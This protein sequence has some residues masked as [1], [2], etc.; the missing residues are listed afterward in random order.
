MSKI[1]SPSILKSAFSSQ[2]TKDRIYNVLLF[3]DGGWLVDAVEVSACCVQHSF[4][5]L[6]SILDPND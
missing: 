5:S 6:K 1:L 3:A 2:T 4:L